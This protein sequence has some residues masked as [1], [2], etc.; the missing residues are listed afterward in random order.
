M[1]EPRMKPKPRPSAR[2]TEMPQRTI[3][4]PARPDAEAIALLIA[5]AERI[6][7]VEPLTDGPSRPLPGY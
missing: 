5:E 2:A 7:G 6:M 3:V 4:R 1:A